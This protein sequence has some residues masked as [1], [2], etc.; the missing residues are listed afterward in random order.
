MGRL[1]QECVVYVENVLLTSKKFIC[2]ENRWLVSKTSQLDSHVGNGSF[3]SKMG[4]LGQ[5]RVV[6]VENSLFLSKKRRK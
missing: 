5:E 3:V 4:R 1:R 2:V 6:Y